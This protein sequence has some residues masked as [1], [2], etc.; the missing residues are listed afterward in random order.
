MRRRTRKEKPLEIKRAN[1]GHA[2]KNSETHHKTMSEQDS[3]RLLK[4][5]TLNPVAIEKE[6]IKIGNLYEG[7][8]T[9]KQGV[10]VNNENANVEVLPMLENKFYNAKEN[11]KGMFFTLDKSFY[12][13]N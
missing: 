5:I 2:S 3:E 8:L 6:Y 7:H 11:S 9:G 10:I 12:E 13:K 4:E 1:P